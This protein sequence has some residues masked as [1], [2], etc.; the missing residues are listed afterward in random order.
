MGATADPR[1]AKAALMAVE[2][3]LGEM[4]QQYFLAIDASTK[5][6]WH[7]LEVKT[8]RRGLNVRARNGYT[9]IDPDGKKDPSVRR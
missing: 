1:S 4:R 2:T 6:G 3:L 8:R 7:R 9:V 5:P